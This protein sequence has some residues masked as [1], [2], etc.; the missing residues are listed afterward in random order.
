MALGCPAFHCSESGLPVLY[1]TDLLPHSRAKIQVV[2]R[3]PVAGL[4][5]RQYGAACLH[6]YKRPTVY[7]TSNIA[8]TDSYSRATV[9]AAVFGWCCVSRAYALQAKLIE[10]S[11]HPRDRDVHVDWEAMA[12][13]LGQYRPCRV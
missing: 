7:G 6:A 10:G 1:C 5:A 12:H 11:E 2:G 8:A 13:H 4:R 9:T 3:L